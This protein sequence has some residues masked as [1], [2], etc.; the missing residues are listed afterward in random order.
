MPWGLLETAPQC[1]SPLERIKVHSTAF[2]KDVRP[3]A[4]HGGRAAK[5]EVITPEFNLVGPVG[6]IDIN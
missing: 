3:H 2:M 6:K 1:P 4:G 5:L